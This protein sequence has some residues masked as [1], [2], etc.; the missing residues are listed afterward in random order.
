MRALQEGDGLEIQSS[1]PLP[2]R[3]RVVV[4]HRLERLS[5]RA[6]QLVAVA[7]I[8][9][10]EF[11]YI[12]LQRA[13]ALGEREAAEGVEELVRRRVVHGVGERFDFI[14]DRIREVAYGQI[15]VPRRKFLHGLVA[16]ALEE[17]YA[18]NLEP[19]YAAL[20]VHYRA[21]G[22][23]EKAVEYLK[24]AGQQAVQQSAYN[25]AVSYFTAALEL[26]Y[27]LPDTPERAR[28]EL[29]LQ[30]ALG[31][32]LVNTKGN[33]DPA[34]KRLYTRAREL[35][36]VVGETSQLFPMLYGLWRVYNVI[37]DLRAAREMA[38]QVLSL[39]Q[40]EPDSRL[41]SE[42]HGMM[43]GCLVWLG[44]VTQARTHLEQSIALYKP[45]QHRSRV[46]AHDVKVYCLTHLA[47]TLWLLGYPDQAL[48][49]VEEA[50]TFARGLS[51]PSSLAHALQWGA[52]IHR[53]RG[54]IQACRECTEVLILL[55]SEQGFLPRLGYGILQQACVLVAEGRV[56]EGIAQMRKGLEAER[57]SVSVPLVSYIYAALADA[58]KKVGQVEDGLK[59]L[60]MELDAAKS[61]GGHL[62][63]AELYRGK[64]ELLLAQEGKD[65][66]ANDKDENVSEAEACFHKGLEVSRS[67][68]AKSLELRAA[69]SLGR[70]WQKQGKKGEAH[71]LL[72]EIYGWFTEGS[73]TADLKEAKELLEGL[74]WIQSSTRKI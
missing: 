8:I 51:H 57:P 55:C 62:W 59:I 29:T 36:E 52:Q 18:D 39:A 64:G 48:K 72:A 7:A 2:E 35:F 5:D 66:E 32:P 74:S 49:R 42:G 12:V 15:L 46:V 17:V 37:G 9:G 6:K 27:T 43:G 65:Q 24:L 40:K 23:R 45:E 47:H 61:S 70:L 58:Y 20:G 1:V 41:L 53:Y 16:R 50:L 68:N 3:V 19:H 14:H 28:E 25:E 21:G 30:I 10:R 56:A 38:E 34:V 4:A 67:Q 69:M 26:L 13:A 44:E 22:V 31:L 33:R 71:K 54:E 60:A 11:D 63:E 73:D